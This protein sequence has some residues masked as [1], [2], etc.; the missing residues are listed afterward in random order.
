MITKKQSV[1]I[2]ILLSLPFIT[3]VG[4]PERPRTHG[5]DSQAL[6]QLVNIYTNLTTAKTLVACTGNNFDRVKSQVMKRIVHTLMRHTPQTPL[7]PHDEKTIARLCAACTLQPRGNGDVASTAV[8]LHLYQQAMDQ[9]TSHH[10]PLFSLLM[11]FFVRLFGKYSR[12]RKN[13]LQQFLHELEEEREKSSRE[14]DAHEADQDQSPE[15]QTHDE[16]SNRFSSLIDSFKGNLEKFIKPTTEGTIHL[17]KVTPGQI[18]AQHKINLLLKGLIGKNQSILSWVKTG[19]KD[20]LSSLSQE[21]K[22]KILLILASHA[23]P[24]SASWIKQFIDQEIGSLDSYDQIQL[25]ATLLENHEQWDAS[26]LKTLIVTQKPSIEQFL[27]SNADVNITQILMGF[28]TAAEAWDIP[29]VHTM[30]SKLFP[31]LPAYNRCELISLLLS[32]RDR[33]DSDLISELIYAS[34]DLIAEAVTTADATELCLILSHIQPHIVDWEPHWVHTLLTSARPVFEAELSL[35][36]SYDKHSVLALLVLHHIDWGTVWVKEIIEQYLQ[37][38]YWEDQ[39]SI[40]ITFIVER[41]KWGIEWIKEIIEDHFDAGDF[42]DQSAIV[43]ALA[44]RTQAWGADWINQWK[45][46][47]LASI[48]ATFDHLSDHEKATLLTKLVEE[49]EI[50]GYAWVTTLINNHR[51]LLADYPE[52]EH[53][54]I[55]REHQHA[56]SH[57]CATG[58]Y[59]QSIDLRTKK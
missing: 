54:A 16:N 20:E 1:I 33:W 11:L 3:V 9:R 48:E 13:A 31:T 51:S 42:E 2:I 46:A 52:L 12:R 10:T 47:T 23:D 4:Q 57:C 37:D 8:S 50:W 27:L 18:P 53:Q 24:A 26:W 43:R 55:H 15:H 38:L 32:H 34:H 35:L 25:I 6:A 28:I 30:I 17:E 7:T 36:D 14:S 40:M 58:F 39:A 5:L 59:T 56:G 21:D 44:Q 49:E 29:W 45:T 22:T 19:L 41:H